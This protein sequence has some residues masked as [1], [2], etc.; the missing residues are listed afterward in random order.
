MQLAS[1]KH[2]FELVKYQLGKG[3]I[4]LNNV[5]VMESEPVPA[6]LQ[7][8]I[9]I[10]ATLL[11]NLGAVF[12]TKKPLV[13]GA[14]LRYQPIRLDDKCNQYLTIDK[15]WLDGKLDMRHFPVGE[16]KFAGVD[17]LIRDFRTSPLPSCIMLAG[18]HAKGLLS[19]SVSGIPVNAK[20]D[21]LFF[22]HT[23]HYTRWWSQRR[24]GEPEEPPILFKYVVNYADG[25]IADIPVIHGTGVGHWIAEQPRGLKEA[26][27]AWAAPFSQDPEKRQ[28]AIYQMP[29]KNPRPG[30]KISSINVTYN[31]VS[32]EKYGVPAVFGITAGIALD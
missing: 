7:K 23:F 8:K 24:W 26:T 6:N 30:Y 11:C 27:V 10:V 17:Y 5:K 18:P 16:N 32:D 13:A 22:L 21:M 20:A 3:G 4:L 14:N 25:A 29:W 2:T 12:A 31:L 28:A 1:G 15:G 19:E 9:T